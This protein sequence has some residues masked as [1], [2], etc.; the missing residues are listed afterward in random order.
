[1]KNTVN[2]TVKV[3]RPKSSPEMKKM[4]IN[5]KLPKWLLDKM[6]LESDSRAVIIE[7]SI[8]CLYDWQPPNI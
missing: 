7:T 4:P 5:V 6:A 1:M 3:G 8:R 2:S